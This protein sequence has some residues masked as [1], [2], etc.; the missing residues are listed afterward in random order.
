MLNLRRSP[1]S[2]CLHISDVLSSFIRCVRKTTI[3]IF[4]LLANHPL[5]DPKGPK[6]NEHDCN[7]L[8][9][10]NSSSGVWDRTLW[11]WLTDRW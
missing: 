7:H 1:L 9:G 5:F 4:P 6:E 10:E 2:T 3:V 8:V 11:P